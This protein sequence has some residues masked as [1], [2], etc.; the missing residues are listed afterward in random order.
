MDVYVGTLNVCTLAFQQGSGLQ[1]WL[2]RRRAEQETQ[3]REDGPSTTANTTTG[4]TSTIILASFPGLRNAS[5]HN[6]PE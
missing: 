2:V 5:T 3:G 4:R 6:E 1:L